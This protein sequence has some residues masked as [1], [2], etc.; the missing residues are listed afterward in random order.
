MNAHLKCPIYTYD[1]SRYIRI[2]AEVAID[3]TARV[4]LI[5]GCRLGL[6]IEREHHDHVMR[7]WIQH[8]LVNAGHV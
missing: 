8:A 2:E 5:P 1:L 7:I 3:S 6:R 4:L